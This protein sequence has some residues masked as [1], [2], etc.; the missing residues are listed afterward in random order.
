MA[1]LLK[2]LPHKHKDLSLDLHQVLRKPHEAACTCNPTGLKRKQIDT[3]VSLASKPNQKFSCLGDIKRPYHKK[4]MFLV[5]EKWHS[6]LAFALCTSVCD[7]HTGMHAHAHTHTHTHKACYQ[8]MSQS[9]VRTCDEEK[10][11]LFRS[12]EDHPWREHVVE[13]EWR[14]MES[15]PGGDASFLLPIQ[16]WDCPLSLKIGK[17]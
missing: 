17:Q 4:T 2:S 11:L 16:L 1:W 12:L 15:W 6:K 10:Q 9:P 3:H 14:K 7:I 8:G 5:P 13:W